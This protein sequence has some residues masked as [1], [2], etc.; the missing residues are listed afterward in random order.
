MLTPEQIKSIRERTGF[1][2]ATSS[3]QQNTSS[4]IDELNQIAETS[5]K[6]MSQGGEDAEFSDLAGNILPSAGRTASTLYEGVAGLSPIGRNE[7]GELS[8]RL[9]PTLE[10]VGKLAAGGV[11]K[12][13]PGEQEH[14]KQF[15]GVT[16]YFADRYGSLENAKKTLINDPVGLALDLASLFS[17]GGALVKGAGL[18]AKSEALAKAGGVIQKAGAAIDPV[19]ATAKVVAGTGKAIAS[20]TREALGF[21]TGAG[22]AAIKEAF[23][24]PSKE[25]T[26][27]LRGKTTGKDI[28]DVARNALNDVEDIRGTE[29]RAR[30]AEISK[31]GDS[32]D[33]SPIISETDKQLGKFGVTVGKDGKLDFERSAITKPEARNGVQELYD[34]INDWG[35]RQ[36]DRTPAMLDI[37]K[38]RL[39]DYN[40]ESGQARALVSG[41]KNKVTDVLNEQVPGYRDMTSEYSQVSNFINELENTLSIADGSK[42]EAAITK[43]TQTLRQDK[44]YRQALVK[45]LEGATGASITPKIAGAALNTWLPRGLTQRL[46]A[47]AGLGSVV[48]TPQFILGLGTALSTLSPRL[49]GEVARGLGIANNKVQDVVQAVQTIKTR[50][51]GIGQMT[52]TQLEQLIYQA[53]QAGSEAEKYE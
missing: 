10:A 53:G 16:Q 18:A 21:T 3:A 40:L 4:F 30:L 26:A 1:Q 48:F 28:V 25:F 31:Q 34:T 11:E 13:I 12:L 38:R 45:Q 5:R 17:G 52:P 33:I 7:S 36:G 46:F 37:L 6:A 44:D 39:G 42:T 29:Y 2:P 32:I 43:L 23:R 15:D 14:E 20:G 41:V 19:R 47:G 22:G 8:L 27:A 9:P 49:V 35:S 24:N 50:V 51:P